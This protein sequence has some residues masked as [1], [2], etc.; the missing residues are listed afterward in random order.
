MPFYAVR[1]GYNPGVYEYLEDAQQ[2][3][4]G[5][6]N[7]CW[8]RFESRDAANDY[9]WGVEEDDEEEDDD[10]DD[11]DYEDD[12]SSDNDYPL[13]SQAACMMEFDGASRSNGYYNQDAGAGAILYCWDGQE[14]SWTGSLRCSLGSASNNQAEYAALILGLEAAYDAGVRK[15][16]VRG[17]SY[18]VKQQKLLPLYE[19]ASSIS[20]S[21]DEFS[22]SW[23]KRLDNSEADDLANQAIDEGGWCGMLD[24]EDG[25]L[26]CWREEPLPIYQ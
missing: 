25:V 6:S 26:A 9:V 15:I 13:N 20:E 7:N 8:R 18:L 19:R 21:F 2:Q 5:F 3:I 4:S 17:D 22:I 1:R 23:Q 10:Y 14:W 24:T 11:D 12:W 16:Q